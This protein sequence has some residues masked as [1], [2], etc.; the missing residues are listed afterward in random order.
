[1]PFYDLH[2]SACKQ[3]FNISASM[4]DKTEKRILC[5]ECG[6]NQLETIYKPV[7]IHVKNSAAACPSSHVCGAGC[8][9]AVGR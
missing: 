2:C 3:D 1:M 5:P 6:S 7:N 8:P 9:H 4:A